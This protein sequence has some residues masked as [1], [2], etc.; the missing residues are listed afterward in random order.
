LT[1]K[2]CKDCGELFDQYT[3]LQ[4]RCNSCAYKASTKNQVKRKGI[5]KVG[6]HALKWKE[7]RAEWIAN[8]TAPSGE[9]QCALQISPLCLRTLTRETITLDHK[10]SRSGNPKLRYNEDNIQPSCIFCNSLKGSRKI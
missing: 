6:K 1:K 8:H 7:F 9:W 3:T 10:L 5:K 2:A 4:T